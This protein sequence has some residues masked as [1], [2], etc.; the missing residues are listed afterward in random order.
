MVID[1]IL[2]V[3]K[4]LSGFQDV[5]RKSDE[6]RRNQMAEYFKTVSTCLHEIATSETFPAQKFA[7]FEFYAQQLPDTVGDEIGHEAA[8]RLAKQLLAIAQAREA[9]A[10]RD[11][12]SELK[13]NIAQ[14]EEA[15]GL[16]EGLANTIKLGQRTPRTLSSTRF[17]RSRARYLWAVPLIGLLGFLAYHFLTRIPKQTGDKLPVI[18]LPI[19][20]APVGPAPVVPENPDYQSRFDSDRTDEL[21]LARLS[22]M[23]FNRGDYAWCIKFLEQARA[24]QSSKVWQADYPFL[25]GS[26]LLLGDRTRAQAA[27]ADMF[28][29]MESGHT[30]L[31][32]EAPQGFVLTNLGNVSSEA[33][34]RG[35][36]IYRLDNRQS[37]A[38]QAAGIVGLTVEGS[39]LTR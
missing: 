3:A 36:A 35:S 31:S 33:T 27:F 38:N 20:S 32:H 10:R 28:E 23:A 39:V 5:L 12:E 9:F 14:V 4:A 17:T 21:K 22:E 1:T 37:N 30:Y 11:S 16:L 29:S 26:Y 24:V 6:E 19:S 25:A 34:T 18:A 7:A 15:S 2:S 8:A 13:S